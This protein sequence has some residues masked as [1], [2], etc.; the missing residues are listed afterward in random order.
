MKDTFQEAR[1]FL[2]SGIVNT[3][4]GYSV[5]FLSQYFLGAHTHYVAAL[6]I[7]YIVS[8]LHSY[9]WLR[10]YVFRSRGPF[11]SQLMGSYFSY[12]GLFLVNGIL[13]TFAVEMFG[14]NVY[15][16]QMFITG[17]IIILSFIV[18]RGLVFRHR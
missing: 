16:A 6:A 13:L 1:R 5:F 10:F 17:A 2:I 12:G 4:F 14:A 11:W 15:L 7:T 8:I 3:V 9:L 18:H